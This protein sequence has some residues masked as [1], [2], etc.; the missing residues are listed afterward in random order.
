MADI[1]YLDEDRGGPVTRDDVAQD[2]YWSR[3]QAAH[4]LGQLPANPSEARKVMQSL[5]QLWRFVSLGAAY[6]SRALQPCDL[7]GEAVRQADLNAEID[8][9]KARAG[10][11]ADCDRA[12][13]AEP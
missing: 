1:L 2:E 8:I 6:R 9:I 7:D 12:V 5:L 11:S 4:L 3:V 10:A 13:D